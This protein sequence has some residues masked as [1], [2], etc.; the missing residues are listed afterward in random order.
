MIIL[1]VLITVAEETVV[2]VE[3]ADVPVDVLVAGVVAVIEFKLIKNFF[4]IE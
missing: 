2:V 1:Q 4:L 3:I